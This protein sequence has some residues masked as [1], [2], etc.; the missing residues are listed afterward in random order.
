M[1]QSFERNDI[2]ENT[3][4]F[5]P[6]MGLC[7]V[8]C[9]EWTYSGNAVIDGTSGGCQGNKCLH[10]ALSETPKWPILN[11][12]YISSFHF[13]YTIMQQLSKYCKIT[14]KDIKSQLII[15]YVM[16]LICIVALFNWS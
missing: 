4:A 16:I 10:M 14:E 3:V 5:Q 7:F 11:H 6:A 8:C 1:M 2:L 15:Y 12:S 9:D 13:E